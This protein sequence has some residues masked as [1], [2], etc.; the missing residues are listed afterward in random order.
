MNFEDVLSDFDLL[1]PMALRSALDLD[2]FQSQL[3]RRSNLLF[4][5]P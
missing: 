5:T 4:L 2:L 3:D 1:R